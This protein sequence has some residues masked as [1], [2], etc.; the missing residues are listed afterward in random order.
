VTAYAW[1]PTL[2]SAAAA[3]VLLGAAYIGVLAG[4]QAVVQLRAPAEFR[5][6]VVSLFLV[7]LGTLY[8]LGALWQ[9]LVGDAL[10]LRWA[11]TIGATALLSLVSGLALLRPRALHALDPVVPA[12]R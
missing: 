10:G 2:W 1:A 9:G 5:G 11:T 6:R 4:L 12:H 3:M 8:P 7:A